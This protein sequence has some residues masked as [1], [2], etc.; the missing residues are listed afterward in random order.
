MPNFPHGM[1][2]KIV[3]VT[4]LRRLFGLHEAAGGRHQVALDVQDAHLTSHDDDDDDDDDLL[5][6]PYKKVTLKRRA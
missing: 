5:I 1:T 2:N 6:S 4:D 3:D